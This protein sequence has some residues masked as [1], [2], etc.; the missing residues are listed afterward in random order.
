MGTDL[1]LHPCQGFLNTFCVPSVCEFVV[2][3][4]WLGI[5]MDTGIEVWGEGVCG[6]GG[7]VRVDG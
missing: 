5:A 4:F 7:W 2:A 3:S 6:G 1:L